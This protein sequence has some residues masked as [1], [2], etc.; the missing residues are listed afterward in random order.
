[1]KTSASR[2]AH[3]QFKFGQHV[4]ALSG[5]NYLF[6]KLTLD[7]IERGQ[8]VIKSANFRVLPASMH[9]LI[10]LHFNLRFPSLGAYE[11]LASRLFALLLLADESGG[12]GASRP[13]SRALIA[14]CL[15][16]ASLRPAAASATPLL[17]NE[18]VD[19]LARL[20]ADGI[21]RTLRYPTSLAR[22]EHNENDN[23][24]SHDDDN[25]SF[26]LFSHD[27][28]KQ[29]WLNMHATKASHHNNNNKN[30]NSCGNVYDPAW[31]H[32]ALATRLMRSPSLRRRLVLHL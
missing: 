9:D 16:S 26:V 13:L 22:H 2:D 21:V 19:L 4:C 23:D 20:E 31:A 17:R 18:L 24:T 25:E 14:E 32:F 27:L 5:A 30:T 6:A 7:L 10:K 12:G 1:M 29:W 15:A 8:L 11:R 28:F 3:L